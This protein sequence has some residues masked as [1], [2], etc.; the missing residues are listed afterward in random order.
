MLEADQR[1]LIGVSK[2]VSQ[3]LL[4]GSSVAKIGENVPESAATLGNDPYFLHLRSKFGDADKHQ[5]SINR[6][7]GKGLI[8]EFE[9]QRKVSAK[10]TFSSAGDFFGYIEDIGMPI[11]LIIDVGFARGTPELASIYPGAKYLAIDPSPAN[12]EWMDDFA[13]TRQGTVSLP[14]ALSN[15]KG[16]GCLKVPNSS[17]NSTLVDSSGDYT[18]EVEV[19]TLDDVISEHATTGWSLLK[20]DTEGNDVRVLKGGAKTLASVGVVM[21]ELRF[22]EPDHENSF[23]AAHKLLAGHGFCLYGMFNHNFS[24]YGRFRQADVIFL[25]KP[26]LEELNEAHTSSTELEQA[27]YNLLRKQKNDAKV[28]AQADADKVISDKGGTS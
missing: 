24:V 23:E 9:R 25:A 21:A 2:Y 8:A 27:A 12:R 18:L 3:H 19:S 10:A 5:K 13:A 1:S 26:F 16:K 7:I 28:K 20:V 15:S 17:T 4:D 22:D 11:S 6:Q 14:L